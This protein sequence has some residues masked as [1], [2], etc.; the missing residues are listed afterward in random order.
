[1][2]KTPPIPP[3]AALHRWLVAGAD[4]A[5]V[6]CCAWLDE[7]RRLQKLPD[8]NSKQFRARCRAVG[9]AEANA[10]AWRE[11]RRR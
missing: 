2:N 9:E 10:E 8:K 11:W 5:A 6:A 4:L 3:N 7:A 1:M